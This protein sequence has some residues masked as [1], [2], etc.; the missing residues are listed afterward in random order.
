VRRK[1]DWLAARGVELVLADDWIAPEERELYAGCVLL[2]PAEQVAARLA[3]LRRAP[4]LARLDGVLLQSEAALPAGA[5][6]AAERGLPGPDPATALRCLDKSATR[7]ALRAAGVAQPE[8]VV[9]RDAAQ[10][11]RFGEAHGW[12]VMVKAFASTMARLVTKVDAPS[13]ADDAVARVRDGLARSLDVA[14]LADFARAARLDL[15][16]DPR[17]AF[18]CESFAPGAPLECDGFVVGGRARPFGVIEQVM[19]PAPHL[20]FEGYLLPADLAAAARDRVAAT[21]ARA[22]EALG[23]DAAGFS[24]ELRFDGEVAR[25]IE[26]NGRLGE[27]H[28]LW[29]LF[30]RAAGRDPFELAVAIALGE[31]PTWGCAS[32]AAGERRHAVAFACQYEERDVTA[33][34]PP[35]DV[36]ALLDGA[37]FLEAGLCV[38]PGDELHAPPHPETFPHLAWLLASDP[39]SS[40]A[41]FAAA[42]ARVATLPIGLAR[43]CYD[44]AP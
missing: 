21:S 10:V 14:R 19:T 3:A 42:R 2:P 5:L 1:R 35:A 16:A 6:L 29:P 15:A 17:E 30:A 34:P 24:V 22:V 13:A 41:A 11:R 44:R 4:E 20:Y 25:V 23:L 31:R 7:A 33:V 32:G 39:A 37:R 26:V 9:A 12:P 8:F 18:L 36:A 28:G 27:D 38:E 43:R 40:R